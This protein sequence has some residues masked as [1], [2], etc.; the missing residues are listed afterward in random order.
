MRPRHITNAK[1]EH[2]ELVRSF[3]LHKY[4]S[5]G[6]FQ[7]QHLEGRTREDV[8]HDVEE[9]EAFNRECEEKGAS[10]LKKIVPTAEQIEELFPSEK[11]EVNDEKHSTEETFT[12]NTSIEGYEI[13]GKGFVV[14]HKRNFSKNAD[15]FSWARMNADGTITVHVASKGNLSD[16]Y[17]DEL[18][19]FCKKFGQKFIGRNYEITFSV[20]GN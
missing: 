18:E 19:A 3:N 7:V 16:D 1:A 15:K 2:H 14:F 5:C 9:V 10:C 13:N 11:P 17:Y 4:F 12:A 8:L 6:Y 20:R